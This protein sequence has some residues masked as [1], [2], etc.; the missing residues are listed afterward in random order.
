M[1]FSKWLQ[2]K[3]FTISLWHFVWLSVLSSLIFTG[4]MSLILRGKIA[5]DYIITGSVVSL[6]VASSVI[7]LI[8]QIRAIERQARSSLAEVN[9]QLH[10]EI[11]TRKRAQKD[12]ET[13]NRAKSD[14]L[15][16]MSHE[17]RTP[18]NHIIGF[19][20]LVK[21]KHFGDLNDTQMEY[22]NDVYQSS[23]HLLSLVSDILD[24]AKIESGKLEL[25]LSGINFTELLQ[26]SLYLIKEKALKHH[27]HLIT[28]IESLPEEIRVDERKLKQVMYNLLSNAIKF[29]PDNGII[30]LHSRVTECSPHSGSSQ[31]GRV[32]PEAYLNGRE[33]CQPTTGRY[34]RFVEVSVADTGIGIRPED[35]ERIFDRFEQGDNS[36][37]RKYQGTGL[38]LTLTRSIVEL[39]GGRFWVES[40]GQ[41]K[42]SRF[43]F[44]IPVRDI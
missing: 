9:K 42:G 36:A 13:A 8:Q 7:C 39:H 1:K 11:D 26:S 23:R 27:I 25:E 15:A 40:E 32:N 19:T 14:F 17:L 20:E 29:T 31:E 18:L 21:D 43:T 33:S 12:A 37:S 30:R 22:L 6:I 5:S 10:Q 35:H 44:T 24:L 4:L 3:L 34:G 16:N 28:D 38:G 41:G 2:D